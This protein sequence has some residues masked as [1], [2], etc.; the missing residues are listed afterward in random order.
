MWQLWLS[1]NKYEFE[2]WKTKEKSCWHHNWKVVI[3]NYGSSHVTLILHNRLTISLN[4]YE[5][6]SLKFWSSTTHNWDRCIVGSSS[7]D[8]GDP[9]WNT[10]PKVPG[11][12]LQWELHDEHQIR[13][14]ISRKPNVLGCWNFVWLCT[15][16][17][18][19]TL[20]RPK[21]NL[22]NNV[23]AQMKSYW[24]ERTCLT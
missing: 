6:P 21:H 3:I 2:L 20:C 19:R 17:S 16:R 5:S 23:T 22:L 8:Q 13:N 9:K 12:L 1:V 24:K 14:G 4:T 7:I 11:H 15:T 18:K 10:P